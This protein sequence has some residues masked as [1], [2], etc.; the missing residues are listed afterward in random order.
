[1]YD[2]ASRSDALQRATGELLVSVRRRDELSVLSGL[3]QAGCL[4]AR[5]PRPA[6]A[7]WF[8]ATTINCSGGVAGGDRLRSAIAVAAGARA[9]IASQAAER[10]YRALPGSAPSQVQ[11][12][13]TI[14]DDA[15]AEWLPQ[16]TILFDGS[17]LE[18]RLV[19]E[20]ADSAVFLGVEMLVFGRAAMGERVVSARLRDLI[21]VRRGG[22]LLLYDAIRLDGAV[23][24]LLQRSAVGGGARAVATL[25][26]VA[27]DA[28]AQL[29]LLRA[30]VAWDKFGA[31]AWNGMLV[32]RLVAPDGATAR[33]L[34]LAALA[35]LRHGRPMP[36]V[37]L[38]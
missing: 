18:R 34:V 15:A 13:V 24:D 25:I 37:W 8:D 16:E 11:T 21:Q 10:Y 38:C 6:V 17:S 29:D 3:R 9:V 19:V 20:M 23:D 28:A 35:V 30:A 22:I 14:E 33:R 36:R 31:S 7:G 4:K 12:A 27:P 32:G 1:M 2:G 5:F 26:Y